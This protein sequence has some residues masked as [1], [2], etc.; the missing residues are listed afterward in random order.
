MSA[1]APS[2]FEVVELGAGDGLATACEADEAIEYE[3]EACSC[4]FAGFAA[5][6]AA[7]D[8]SDD[9]HADAPGPDAPAAAPRA[10]CRT[11]PS[12]L[13]LWR[14]RQTNCS[15]SPESIFLSRAGDAP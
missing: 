10:P 13:A 5:D 6:D 15:P 4:A 9:V 1:F 8:D 12:S 14:S 2:V 7:D 11:Q 3:L